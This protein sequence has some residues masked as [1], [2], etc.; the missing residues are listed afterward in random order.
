[1]T[2]MAPALG[3]AL[4][5]LTACGGSS[6]G[7]AGGHATKATTGRA[8]FQSAGCAGCHTLRAAG[9]TGDVGP[10]LDSLQ[11][12][13]ATVRFQV[14]HGGGVMPSFTGTLTA[15]QINAVANFVASSAGH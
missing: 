11:P 9:A 15:A 3:G 1:M 2:A 13:A 4:V 14:E 5:G 12:S 8:I 7:G 6:G 10:N